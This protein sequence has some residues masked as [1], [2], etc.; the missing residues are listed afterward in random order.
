MTPEGIHPFFLTRLASLWI[1]GERFESAVGQPDSL[2]RSRYVIETFLQRETYEKWKDRDGNPVLSGDGH[3]EM[4]GSVAEEM[5]RSGAFAFDKEELRIAAEIGQTDGGF[6]RQTIS[7]ALNRVGTHAALQTTVRGFTF[8]HD[9]FLHYFL[10]YRIQKWL[11]AGQDS[12]IEIFSARELPPSVVEWTCWSL[13][14]DDAI[15]MSISE[16]LNR[17][18]QEYSEGVGSENIGCLVVQLLNGIKPQSPLALVGHTI[19]GEALARIMLTG[20]EFRNCRF[21]SLDIDES[22]LTN[23]TFSKCQFGDVRIARNCAFE[24]IVFRECSFSSLKIE[25]QGSYFSPEDIAERLAILGAEVLQPA[26][27]QEAKLVPIRADITDLVEITVKASERTCD[28]AL[29]EFA[30]GQKLINFV[31]RVGEEQGTLREIKKDVSGPKKR[32]VRFSVDRNKLLRGKSEVT[33]DLRIDG[34]WQ[35]L[36]SKTRP[37]S[38]RFHGPPS[39]NGWEVF[40]KKRGRLQF[41]T[42]FLSVHTP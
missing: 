5:W 31:I 20:I 17:L 34:F 42:S 35:E 21:W 32:F 26:V 14:G 38:L 28:V 18:A 3:R 7:D 33:G 29:E 16:F 2:S 30:T 19:V 24:K 40:K 39:A 10:A 37:H 36:R 11:R 12:V 15:V 41:K 23:C 27:G 13:N 1:R 9:R 8:V 22:T 6:A 4:L 25:G